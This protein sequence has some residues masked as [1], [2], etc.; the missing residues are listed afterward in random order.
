MPLSNSHGLH[1][2]LT[3]IISKHET[4]RN[5][6]DIEETDPCELETLETIL[7]S[8]FHKMSEIAQRKLK[9]CKLNILD[10]MNTELL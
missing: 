4:L 10:F 5:A 3:Q 8:K 9:N 2:I 6:R 1:G 7:N